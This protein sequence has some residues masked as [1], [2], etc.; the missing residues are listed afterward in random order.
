MQ[1]D[2]VEFSTTHQETPRTITQLKVVRVR[3]MTLMNLFNYLMKLYL[4][5]KHGNLQP[6]ITIYPKLVHLH[7]L[8]HIL[9]FKTNHHIPTFIWYPLIWR[10]NNFTY[11]TSWSNFVMSIEDRLIN[12][13]LY[14]M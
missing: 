5:D 13:F 4:F 9:V 7:Q 1:K 11:L 6:H 8:Q 10:W 14:H 12:Q 2:L 3:N